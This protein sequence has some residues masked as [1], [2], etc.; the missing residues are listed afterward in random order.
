[1]IHAI[2]TNLRTAVGTLAVDDGIDK[3]VAKVVNR[4]EMTWAHKIDHAPVLLQVVLQRR[5][6]QCEKKETDEDSEP[7]SKRR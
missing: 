3:H 1:M 6:D 7:V 4:P 2:A 5:A